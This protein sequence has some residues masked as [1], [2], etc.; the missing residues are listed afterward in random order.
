MPE[1]EIVRKRSF[2]GAMLHSTLPTDFIDEGK[3][4]IVAITRQASYNPTMVRAAAA[5]HANA[6]A[7]LA[8]AGE[9]VNMR[10]ERGRTP[11]M[12]CV[13]RC[14]SLLSVEQSLPAL[15]PPLLAFARAGESTSGLAAW[16]TAVGSLA[17]VLPVPP[18]RA[19]RAL[20]LP[21]VLNNR[22]ASLPP[23]S[24]HDRPASRSAD[25]LLSSLA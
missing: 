3:H 23:A 5:G 13:S 12:A 16:R 2:L 7:S 9:D 22:D 1:G 20:N 6:I 14:V 25:P 4:N 10:N 21:C 8:E 24:S 11:M 19:F 17:R 18:S 15:G